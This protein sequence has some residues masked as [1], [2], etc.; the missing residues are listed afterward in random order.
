MQEQEQ[1]Q[2][3]AQSKNLQ[4]KYEKSTTH[5]TTNKKRKPPAARRRLS[6]DLGVKNNANMPALV[7]VNTK[8]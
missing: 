4:G 1:E 8:K 5:K 3:Q 6:M 2:A 7:D